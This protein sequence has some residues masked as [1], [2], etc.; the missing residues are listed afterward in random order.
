M[1]APSKIP[2]NMFFALINLIWT[3]E[4]EVFLENDRIYVDSHPRLQWRKGYPGCHPSAGCQLRISSS[5]MMVALVKN[6]RKGKRNSWRYRS[7]TPYQSRKRRRYQDR[8]W[9]G[10]DAWGR[11]HRHYGW[12]WSTQPGRY[13]SAHRTELKNNHCDVVLGTHLIDS[14]GMPSTRSLP[15][16]LAMLSPGISTVSRVSDGRS[17]YRASPRH[18]S[19]LQLIPRPTRYEYDSEVNSGNL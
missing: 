9:G 4:R 16:G 15:T 17:N 5:S 6:L 19:K 2:I 11:R 1:S 14:K 13:R 18:A 12:W 7:E 10:Q 3:M 8:Y